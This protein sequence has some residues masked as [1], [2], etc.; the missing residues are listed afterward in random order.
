MENTALDVFVVG[1]RFA[2]TTSE[3]FTNYA[4]NGLHL[5]INVISAPGTDTITPKLQ[6]MVNNIYYDLLE[7]APID[8]TGITVLKIHPGISPIAKF[9]ANDILP[10]KWRVIMTHSAATNFTYSVHANLVS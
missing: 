3:V 4:S 9:S 8:S 2:T 6:G 5:I 10:L 1:T 7:S